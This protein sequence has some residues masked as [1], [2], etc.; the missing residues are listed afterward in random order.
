[1]TTNKQ[2]YQLEI[3]LKTFEHIFIEKAHNQI[4][5]ILQL[6]HNHSQSNKSHFN[7]DFQSNQDRSPKV[8]AKPGL[9]DRPTFQFIVCPLPLKMARYTVIR[10][11]HIDKKSRDQFEIRQYKAIL[12]HQGQWSLRNLH[13]FLENLKHTKFHGVQMQIRI[14]SSSCGPKKN[15]ILVS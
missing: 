8:Q 7:E 15:K 14:L 2:S 1:M 13:F 12:K 6:S 3:S 5:T 11:P 10:S 4:N 9:Y